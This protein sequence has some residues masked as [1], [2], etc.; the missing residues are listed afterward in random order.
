MQLAKENG[1]KHLEA[2]GDSKLIVNQVRGEYE[3]RHEDLPYYN[4]IIN[5]IKEFKSFYINHVPRQQNAHANVLASLAA[6]LAL[7][8][9][10]TEEVLVHSRDLY[11]Q[12][13]ALEDGKTPRGYLQVKEVLETSTSSEPRD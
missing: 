7:S 2:Y 10:T 11:C 5:M 8:A 6:S 9:G 4:A 1:V 3:V 12:K 13:F